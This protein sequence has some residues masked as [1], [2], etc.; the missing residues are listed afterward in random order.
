[1]AVGARTDLDRNYLGPV[2]GFWPVSGIEDPD[3]PQL[4]VPQVQQEFEA[5][6]LANMLQDNGV[7]PDVIIG[8]ARGGLMV[9]QQLAY[10]NEVRLVAAAQTI[11]YGADNKP[12]EK[13]I[14]GI[15]PD[16]ATFPERVRT[17]KANIL[18]VDE[19]IEEGEALQLICSWVHKHFRRATITTAVI[20]DKDHPHVMQPDF[21]LRK[22]PDLWLDHESQASRERLAFR[23]AELGNRKG[24]LQKAMAWLMFQEPDPEM[25]RQLVE[26][27]EGKYAHFA[28]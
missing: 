6:C 16:P 15:M 12:L 21:V 22:V 2:A 25:L 8:V 10:N 1:M 27:S 13:P 24:L 20:Y 23:M 18:V 28:A 5:R 19:L 9:A 14:L 3:K 17:S 11:G 4:W 26:D 7:L